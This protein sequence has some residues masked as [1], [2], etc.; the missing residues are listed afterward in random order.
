MNDLVFTWNI[1]KNIQLKA[2]RG[3][4][5]EDVVDAIRNDR[6]L[7]QT[8]NPSSNFPEQSIFIVEIDEYAIVVPFVRDGN[9]V[10]LK[11]LFPERKARKKFLQPKPQV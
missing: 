6:L 3:I 1:E 2:E 11:T 4:G 10:F 9:T 5:F 7:A 8:D